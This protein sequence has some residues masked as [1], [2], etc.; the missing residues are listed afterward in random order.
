MNFNSFEFLIFLAIV[1]V[2][3]FVLPHKFR[4]VMLLVASYYFYMS[5]NAALIFL[6]F[7]TTLISYLAALFIEKTEKKSIKKL[8][9]IL[10]L[11]VCLGVLAFFK[12]ANFF[13][14]SVIDFLNLFKMNL[15]GFALNILLPV[16]IS[17]YTFQ[18]LSYVIDVYRGEYK[19]EKHFGYY[20]LFVS[21]FPQL[22]AGPIERCDNLLPQLKVEHKLNVDDM[23]AGLRI[24]LCGFFFKCVVADFVGIYVNNV[25]GNLENANALSVF[26][27]GALFNVQI[28]CDF[29]GYSEIAR[30]VA[31]MMGVKLMKNFDRPFSATSYSELNRRWHISLNQWFTDY[32]YI[33]LGGGRKGTV[34]KVINIFIVF[35]LSGLWHGASWTYVL[36]GCYAAFFLALEIVLYKPGRKLL[37]K[38]KIDSKS[39]WFGYFRRMLVWPIFMIAGLLF[40]AQSL[41]EIGTVFT[42]LFTEMGIG[43]AYL[44]ATLDNLGV[45]VLEILQIVL[46]F[47]GMERMSDFADYEPLQKPLLGLEEKSLYAQRVS[48]YCYAILAIMLCWFALFASSDA[49]SFAYF[50]F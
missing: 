45:G 39:Q 9:L 6:I 13:I 38:L 42:K 23:S 2:L 17:F 22:V 18:T 44:T 20:A 3:Y 28:Y 47:I 26:L 35:A 49:S 25:F 27:T 14:G 15:D 41:T 46:C 50:Q 8:W 34:R 30:G 40:R 33:P 10:T 16:G 7:G 48:V 32:V 11:V 37:K 5:W 19:A 29:A 4:W 36:W 24:A 21:Y 12:Y 43:E 31:R 1:L